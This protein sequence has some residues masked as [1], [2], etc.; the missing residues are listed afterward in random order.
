[1]N[2]SIVYR[3]S[4]FVQIGSKYA[5]YDFISTNN[6]DAFIVNEYKGVAYVTFPSLY[7]EDFV[8]GEGGYRECNIQNVNTVSSASFK[9]DDDMPV[10]VHKGALSLFL[11]QSS[12]FEAQESM[13]ELSFPFNYVERHSFSWVEARGLLTI[14]EASTV[15]S[16]MQMILSM[17]GRQP[18]DGRGKVK[19]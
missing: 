19:P 15:E 13:L 12:L 5:P 10:L 7:T 6:V 14:A 1:M 2:L 11:Q 4:L 8:V 18:Q 3:Y 9:G 16:G 17:A